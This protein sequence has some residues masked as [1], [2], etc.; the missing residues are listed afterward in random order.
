MLEDSARS[1]NVIA[2]LT[3]GTSYG[4]DE[5]SEHRVLIVPRAFDIQQAQL[6]QLL[7]LPLDAILQQQKWRNGKNGCSARFSSTT[8][9]GDH[10]L[11]LSANGKRSDMFVG[12]AKRTRELLVMFCRR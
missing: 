3:S 1:Q 12:Y 5:Q 4:Y 11:S 7:K 2:K 8:A 10:M 6:R 9:K